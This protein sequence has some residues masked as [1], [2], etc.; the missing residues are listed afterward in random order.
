LNIFYYLTG[1]RVVRAA[2]QCTNG[3]MRL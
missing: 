1:T 3:L 2:G